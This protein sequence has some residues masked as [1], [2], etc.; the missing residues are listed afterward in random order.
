MMS[1][2]YTLI[3]PLLHRI[4]PETAHEWAI[5][6][7]AKHLVP[8][9]NA[10]MDPHLKQTLFGL[11]FDNPVGLA[12]GFDKNG[13]AVTGLSRQGFGFVEV[14]TV[15][16]KPQ[17]GN[18]KPRIFR[19]NKDQAVI[20]RLG[21]NNEGAAAMHARLAELPTQPMVLGVNIGRNKVCDDPLQDYHSLVLKMADVA[22]YIT[23][24]ISSPNT[25]GLRDMQQKR[26]LEELLG[27]VN[28][29]KNKLGRPLPTLLK[30]APDIDDMMKEDIAEVALTYKLDGLIVS[31]TTI[32]RPNTLQSKQHGEVGG[33]SGKPLMAHSTKVLG[34]IY[35]L[36]E[37]KIPLVGVGGIASAKDAYAKIQAGASL[38]QAYTAFIYQGFGLVG[39]INRGLVKL[40]ERDGFGNI[41]EAV[42]SR[43]P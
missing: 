30:I 9:S 13:E 29:A 16:P 20:N 21:F 2:F 5:A 18:P 6:A 35:R 32:K 40:L 11:T 10:V 23:V 27:T 12:A 42:G 1:P 7:L 31:N 15:T 39:K 19:L 25:Q 4:D 14:G 26:N 28:A 37:G 43:A 41:S 24:N 36:T 3:R 8:T 33:L 17:D 22:D 38:V 34:D